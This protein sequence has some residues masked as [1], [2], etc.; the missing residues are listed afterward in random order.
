MNE[1]SRMDMI[2]VDRHQLWSAAEDAEGRSQVR[3]RERDRLLSVWRSTVERVCGDAAILDLVC[4]PLSP[5]NWEP[6]YT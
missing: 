3:V 5:T 6:C 2:C 1:A 4:Q